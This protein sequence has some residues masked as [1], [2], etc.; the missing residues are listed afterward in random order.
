[1][2]N[3]LKKYTPTFCLIYRKMIW[4]L[5]SESNKKFFKAFFDKT[6]LLF[7]RLS[8]QSFG[9]CI[10]I[11]CFSFSLYLS[12]SRIQSWQIELLS[13]IWFYKNILYLWIISLIFSFIN[14]SVSQFI[15][16]K[17]YRNIF[18]I[19][20]RCVLYLPTFFW[21]YLLILNSIRII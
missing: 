11:Y 17:K 1:M 9:L 4:I 18:S 8:F 10:A 13:M 12:D 3:I 20:S 14:F 16:W 15:S 19:L 5:S 6:N 7:A 2:E 21:S